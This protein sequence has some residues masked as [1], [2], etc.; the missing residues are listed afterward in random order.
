MSVSNNPRKPLA[1]QG[2][3]NEVSRIL[4]AALE[5]AHQKIAAQESIIARLE[6]GE[7]RFHC[8]LC[9]SWVW[10]DES[11]PPKGWGVLG[12]DDQ[13]QPRHICLDCAARLPAEVRI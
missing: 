2:G 5:R 9:S 10:G 11:G 13:G 12:R 4:L 8:F 7:R 6:A 3:A 1:A